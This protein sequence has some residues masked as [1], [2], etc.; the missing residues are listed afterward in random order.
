MP[1]GAETLVVDVASSYGLLNS[2]RLQGRVTMKAPLLAVILGEK[3][4]KRIYPSVQSGSASCFAL[5]SCLFALC[6]LISDVL[7]ADLLLGD[8]LEA[9]ACDSCHQAGA[10]ANVSTAYLLTDTQH[11]LCGTCHP[12]SLEATHPVGIEPSMTAPAVLPYDWQGQISCS[13]C[14]AVHRQGHAPLR[15]EDRGI[16]FCIYCHDLG[17]FLQMVDQGLSLFHSGH[18]YAKTDYIE[19]SI[20]PFSAHCLG[21]HE[22]M[23]E[24]PSL[25]NIRANHPVL[26]IYS[27]TTCR[28]I[29]EL[30][31][32]ILTPGGNVSCISC[33]EGYSKD[34]GAIV[35]P[36]FGSGLC[37]GCHDL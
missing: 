20:D 26:V 14:H 9:E 36:M 32:E 30:D 21:C 28:T 17:F 37:N 29:D 35:L 3:S 10:A 23:M 11:H 15:V 18:L 16:S 25:M 4:A 5:C 22:E 19:E 13:T 12:G 8:P 33:H 6:I 31:R 1:K 2:C 34:H 7:N 27:C 24:Q